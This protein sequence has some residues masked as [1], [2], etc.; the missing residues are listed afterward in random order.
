MAPSGCKSCHGVSAR[1]LSPHQ[2][3]P[4]VLWLSCVPQ[5]LLGPCKILLCAPQPLLAGVHPLLRLPLLTHEICHTHPLQRTRATGDEA[6]QVHA[7]V[8]RGNVATMCV[9]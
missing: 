3:L 2:S 5:L 6:T 7:S 9:R 4:R 8:T 1:H